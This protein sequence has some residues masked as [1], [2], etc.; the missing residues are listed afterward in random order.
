VKSF[1]TP[2]SFLSLSIWTFRRINLATSECWYSY[3]W[4]WK[5]NSS[6]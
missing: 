5:N 1:T 4:P 2:F 3:R 6:L